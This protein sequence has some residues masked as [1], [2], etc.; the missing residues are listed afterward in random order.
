VEKKK[1]LLTIIFCYGVFFF[2]LL[3]LEYFWVRNIWSMTI[4]QV[5]V[6]IWI[7]DCGSIFKNFSNR[8][9]E[10]EISKFCLESLQVSPYNFSAFRFLKGLG[11]VTCHIILY[12]IWIGRRYNPKTRTRYVKDNFTCFMFITAAIVS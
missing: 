5:D 9:L 8:I 10:L 7:L 4:K 11:F 3:G 2:Y 1:S 6:L 12:V